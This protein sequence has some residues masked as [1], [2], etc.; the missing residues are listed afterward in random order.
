MRR[1]LFPS[2]ATLICL[3]VIAGCTPEQEYQTIKGVVM[4]YSYQIV[5][6]APDYAP[7]SFRSDIKKAARK[8]AREIDR[9][10]SLYNPSSIINSVN[11]NK[12][13]E[14]DSIFAAVLDKTKA[15]AELTGASMNTTTGPLREL[16]GNNP[17]NTKNVTEDQIAQVLE[18]SGIWKVSVQNGLFV[19]EDPRIQLDLSRTGI[20]F[21][22]DYLGSMLDS[23]NISN[24][25][26]EVGKVVLC[27]GLNPS[28]TP[29]RYLIQQTYGNVIYL[30]DKSMSICGDLSD[31]KL[32]LGKTFNGFFNTRTGYPVED[33]I[34]S[35][36]VIA[37]NGLD[38]AASSV[39]FYS[40]GLEKSIQYLESH[41]DIQAI[42]Y[43]CNNDSIS[44]YIT[45]NITQRYEIQYFP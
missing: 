35:I 5:Y 31:F 10:I 16:W 30:T 37:N 11:T 1:I 8:C 38:A 22:A 7:W 15:T 21:A 41:P 43:Y 45:P 6:Q 14:T 33:P 32:G 19:K 3:L 2:M 24:Y 23:N 25:M 13:M 40:L 9:S 26:I 44:T 42:M 12:S 20:G 36:L 34:L 27:K 4:G 18:Y 29:W 17:G 28:G 39:A